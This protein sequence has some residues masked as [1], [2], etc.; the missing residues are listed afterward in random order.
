MKKNL[1]NNLCVISLGGSLVV[2]GE[3]DVAFLKKFRKL[4]LSEIRRGRR[5]ICIVGGGKIARQYQHAAKM[6]FKMSNEDLDWL[7][8]HATRLNAHLL[9]TIFRAVAYPK[10]ITS[11]KKIHTSVNYPVIIASGFRPGASTDFC[12]VKLAKAFGAQTILNL[13]NIDWVYSKDPNTYSNAK[14]FESMTWHKFRS[15][16]GSHWDP[17]ANVPFDPKASLFASRW[18][19]RVIVANGKD[20]K[21]VRA[22]IQGKKGKGTIIE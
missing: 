19:L 6:V 14:K 3:V 13:S 12:A 4:L 15:L 10:I 5:F 17:G 20:L 22:L 11:S 21:N 9:R 8:I 16:F 1:P 7:G 2:P 18:G